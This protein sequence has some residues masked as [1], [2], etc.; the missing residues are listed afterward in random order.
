MA[1]SE[2]LRKKLLQRKED[3]KKGSGGDLIIFKEGTTRFRVLP[4]GEDSDFA[5]EVVQFYLGKELGGIISPATFGE[6]C[7]IMERYNELKSGDEDEQELAK[8]FRPRR[9]FFAPAV[10]YNDEKGKELDLTPRLAILTNEMY[11]TLIDMMLD[12]EKGDFTD[13]DE[14]YDLK[15]KR[16]GTGQFDTSYKVFDT[17]PT[18]LAD[19]ELRKKLF[20]PEDMVREMLPTYEQTEEK[21]NRFLGISSDDDEDEKPKKKKKP[22]SDLDEKPKKKKKVKDDEAPKKKKKK[23]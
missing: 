2:K 7:A 4:C 3:I 5:Q 8:T 16:E 10:K 13:K 19:K 22:S 21:I 17:K 18:K 15:V 23:K 1:V 20:N 6:P 9:R 14:G 11:D 12:E